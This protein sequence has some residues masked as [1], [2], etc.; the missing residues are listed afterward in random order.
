MPDST[1]STLANIQT[2]IRRITRSPSTAQLSDADINNYINNFVLYDFP[3][4]LRQFSLRTT[5]T[6]Y[7]QPY[8]DTY[9]TNTVN[10][11]DPLYN[12]KNKY[13]SIHEP[14]YI[15]G[16]QS[17]FTQSR[18]QFYGIYPKVNSIQSI[19]FEGDG[20][21][22][23]YTGTLTNPP[24]LMNN[25]LFS[26]V[27]INNQG[28]AVVDKPVTD[29]ITGYPETTGNLINQNGSVVVGTINYVTGAYDITFDYAPAS[30][31]A[32]DS[33]TVPIIVSL[34]QACLYY[35]D[36]FTVRPVPDQP[37]RVDFEAYIRPVELLAIDQQPELSQW[38]QYI[39]YGA[40]I[41]VFQDRMDLESVSLI[42]PEF[43]NQ[44]RLVIRRTIVQ[45]TQERTATIYTEQTGATT[46][47]NG[48]GWGGGL[49]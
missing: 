43:K 26:S 33:Q 17:F 35:N 23:H 49:F 46:G 42:M 32:I 34:P 20:V 41:K 14:L 30:G 13:I 38:W 5:I 10:A 22:T 12:F 18:E 2:K 47:G 7:T 39:A 45:Q 29:P 28:L 9:S 44:E 4:Q 16:Y 24:L 37:Y 25:I 19:G 8:I 3:E 31:Q 40:A 15:A 21:T 27:D 6:F 36:I 48:W 11:D 1:L